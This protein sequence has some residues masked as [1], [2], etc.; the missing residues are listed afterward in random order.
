[1]QKRKSYFYVVLVID[2]YEMTLSDL[3]LNF[4]SWLNDD[5]NEEVV[6]AC[7]DFSIHRILAHS[8]LNNRY[9]FANVLH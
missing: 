3:I 8:L 7:L 4:K 6:R 5:R 1:M 9:A 2:E